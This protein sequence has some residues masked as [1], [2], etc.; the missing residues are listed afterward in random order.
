[1]Y[2]YLENEKEDVLNFL[3][4]NVDLERD[5]SDGE[6]YLYVDS[7][8]E[9]LENS[10]WLEDSVTGNAS[11]SYTFNREEARGYVED[12]KE[13]LKEAY[14]ELEGDLSEDYINSDYE[15]MDVT[16]RCCLLDQAI[17]A[18]LEEVKKGWEALGINYIAR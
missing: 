18:A 10:L 15:K 13:L 1:M 6:G 17:E 5:F 8:R 2:D 11:G 7:L 9:F 3:D 4:E 14:Q 16:I 12:N